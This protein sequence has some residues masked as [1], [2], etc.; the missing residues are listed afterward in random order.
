MWHET[1]VVVLKNK[2]VGKKTSIVSFSKD[3]QIASK[4]R[5]VGHW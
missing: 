2:F 3:T 1:D 4:A 5:G